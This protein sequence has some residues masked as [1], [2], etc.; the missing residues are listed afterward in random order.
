MRPLLAGIG[1]APASAAWAASLRQ[2]PG[3]DQDRIAWA[4]LTGPTPS[5]ASSCGARWVDQVDEVAFVIGEF[6]VDPADGEGEAASLGAPDGVFAG[7]VLTAAAA[8]DGSEPVRRQR[9]AGQRP[10]GVAAGEQ[11]RA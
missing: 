1:L 11:Q 5:L 7:F 8:G 4:A 9:A 6:S 2:R 10:V 3:W